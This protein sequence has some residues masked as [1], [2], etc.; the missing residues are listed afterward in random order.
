MSSGLARLSAADRLSY[1]RLLTKLLD[2]LVPVNC[3]GEV[4]MGATMNRVTLREMS[5]AD[6]RQYFELLCKVLIAN[7]RKSPSFCPPR[8]STR[9]RNGNCR[10][11]CSFIWAGI[12]PTSRATRRM[13]GIPR[14]SHWPT[15]AGLRASRCTRSSQCATLSGISSCCAR[16]CKTGKTKTPQAGRRLPQDRPSRHR[17][18]R[19]AR[20]SHRASRGRKESMLQQ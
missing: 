4:D 3:F 10:A 12:H 16:S 13:R 1:V 11:R 9:L 2:E 6:V 18:R 15:P 19:R 5:D 8:S 17:H 20:L 7:A 14:R